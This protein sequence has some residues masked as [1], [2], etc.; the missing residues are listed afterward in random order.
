MATLYIAEFVSIGGTGNFPIQSPL[1]PPVAEQTVSIGATSAQ[2]AVFNANTNFVR[3]ATDSA[4][5]VEFGANPTA[6]AAK[7]R[8]PA[9]QTEYFAVMPGQKVAVITNS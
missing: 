9:N 8:L 2:S 6:T 4:C 1:A 5:S 3:L 7:M